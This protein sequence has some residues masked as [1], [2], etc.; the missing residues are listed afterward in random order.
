MSEN[1]RETL[2]KLY[3]ISFHIASQRLQFTAF[4]NQVPLKKIHGVKFTGAYENENASK[5]FIFGICEYL[6]YFIKFPSN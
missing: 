3:N 6:F 2:S 1:D 5:N 4:Q